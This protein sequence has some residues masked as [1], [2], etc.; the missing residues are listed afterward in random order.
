MIKLIN[1]TTGGE[2]WVHESRVEEYLERGHK[3]APLPAPPEKKRAPA[4]RA[5]KEAAE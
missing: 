4:K 5:K 1:A 2:T 3:L